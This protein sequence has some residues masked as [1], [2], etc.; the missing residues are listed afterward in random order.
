MVSVTFYI[1]DRLLIAYCTHK[2]TVGS[3]DTPPET[4]F[5]VISI[6]DENAKDYTKIANRWAEI[7]GENLDQLI[8]EKL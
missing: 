5:T 7:K 3:R 1:D 8:F 2:D 6:E 4:D